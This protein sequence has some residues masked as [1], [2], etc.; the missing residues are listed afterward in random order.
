MGYIV[1][2]M[3]L[4]KYKIN[5]VMFYRIFRINLWKRFL[6]LRGIEELFIEIF[7]L[8]CIEMSKLDM[9]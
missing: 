1:I 3:C 8:Y 2:K 5:N 4:F 6:F 9:L 7:I